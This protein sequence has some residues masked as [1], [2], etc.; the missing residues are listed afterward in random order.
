MAEDRCQDCRSN[1]PPP[2]FG[3]REIRRSLM[4]RFVILS[5]GECLQ[6][7]DADIKSVIGRLSEIRYRMMTDKPLTDFTDKLSDVDVWNKHL[8]KLRE[9]NGE[10]Q[11]TWYK[12]D[13]LFVECY[14]Y[15]KVA[16]FFALTTHLQD[17]DCFASQKQNSF[18]DCI[19]P[20]TKIAEYCLVQ[21][22]TA[23]KDE[24][25]SALHEFIEVCLWGNVCDLSLS[26]G[27]SHSAHESPIELVT[28]VR[29]KILANNID[30]V[31]DHLL[32]GESGEVNIVADNASIELVGDIALAAFL[33]D[34][35]LA[36]KV[37]FHLKVRP[38]FVSDATIDD[39]TWTVEMMLGSKDETLKKFGK[40]LMERQNENRLE[41]RTHDFWTYGFPY[42]KMVEIS[43]DLYADLS[44]AKLTIFKGD[45][46]Y[47]K[48]VGDCD[49]KYNEPFK[50]VLRGFLPSPLLALRTL[51]AETV[52]GIPDEAIKSI[53]EKYGEENKEW[54]VKG[55]YAVAQ[56]AS[57]E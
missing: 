44:S 32:K 51:K 50:T 37:V 7:G 26:G 1:P 11:V 12:S 18:I 27:D 53:R 8:A 16:E 48:L 39:F 34:Y 31:V 46:N 47:R 2:R 29:N 3:G 35:N 24:V 40:C 14:L 38:W 45:L 19:A 13:W 4:T 25:K 17:Y 9:T 42:F 10:G 20:I 22:S 33:L 30:V 36:S 15:R 5:N 6:K 52:A 43:P 21:S 55:E 49:W 57:K 56:W 41:F 23:S 28:H 54:M